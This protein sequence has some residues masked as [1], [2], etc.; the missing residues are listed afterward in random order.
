M[1]N[2]AISL[3]KIIKNGRRSTKEIIK[4][5]LKVLKN[6]IK[7]TIN[8]ISIKKDILLLA[9]KDAKIMVV[10]ENTIGKFLFFSLLKKSRKIAI[11]EK[12]KIF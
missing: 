7:K 3:I 12:I 5:F 10:K 9:I 2:L 8:E 11:K 6:K 4:L 1:I